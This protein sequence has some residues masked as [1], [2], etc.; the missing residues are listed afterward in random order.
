MQ[1]PHLKWLNLFA[2]AERMVNRKTEMVVRVVYCTAK[3][4]NQ[5]HSGKEKRQQEYWNALKYH[6]VFIKKG[7]FTQD[8]EQCKSCK[9]PWNDTK[10]KQSD[11]N[12]A[13]EMVADA[14]KNAFDRAYLLTADTDQGATVRFIKENFPDKKVIAVTPPKRHQHFELTNFAHGKMTLTED[15]I[16][17]CLLDPILIDKSEGKPRLIYRMPL[18]YAPPAGWVKPSNRR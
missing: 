2:L 13:I 14:Y 9:K 15:Q 17:D 11:V 12:L 18:E 7:F 10:E 1:Q 4:K 8:L 3:V 6:G 5:M 16:G